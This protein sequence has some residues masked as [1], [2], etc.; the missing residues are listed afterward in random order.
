MTPQNKIILDIASI[1][2]NCITTN[3]RKKLKIYHNIWDYLHYLIYQYLYF[4]SFY[5]FIYFTSYEFTTLVSADGLSLD[6]EW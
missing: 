3:F 6:S 1:I 2:K 4:I 5:L